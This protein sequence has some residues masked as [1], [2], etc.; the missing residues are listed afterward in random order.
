MS[1]MTCMNWVCAGTYDDHERCVRKLNCPACG[2]SDGHGTGS[3]NRYSVCGTVVD[4]VHPRTTGRERNCAGCPV[5]S[6]GARH[7]E[8]HRTNCRCTS[9]LEEIVELESLTSATGDCRAK[10]DCVYL[11]HRLW[12]TRI[13]FQ[14]RISEVVEKEK[15]NCESYG[16]GYGTDPGTH[17]G[18]F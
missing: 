17:C 3:E 8:Y 7:G 18:V 12:S 16:S 15:E 4:V 11:L 14:E 10:C 9:D 5:R 1:I 6:T 13:V 2:R